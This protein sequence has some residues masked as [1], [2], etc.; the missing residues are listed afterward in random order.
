MQSR[1]LFLLLVLGGCWSATATVFHLGPLIPYGFDSQPPVTNWLLSNNPAVIPASDRLAWRKIGEVVRL[2]TPHSHGVRC[3]AAGGDNWSSSAEWSRANKQASRRHM[4]AVAV[5]PTCTRVLA[6]YRSCR[7]GQHGA[8]AAS[9]LLAA[10]LQAQRFGRCCQTMTSTA[11]TSTVRPSHHHLPT[12]SYEE[13]L[14]DVD[15]WHAS[16]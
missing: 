13:Q 1:G 9:H 12:N 16:L 11:S 15:A 14:P 10:D 6:H 3:S 8:S 7:Q 4:R 2:E 5:V